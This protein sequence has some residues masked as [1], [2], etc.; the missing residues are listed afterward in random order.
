MRKKRRRCKIGLKRK[1]RRMK[2]RKMRKKE[3]RKTRLSRKNAK[4]RNKVR[5]ERRGIEIQDSAA[6]RRNARRQG[7]GEY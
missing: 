6:T 3:E 1:K 5:K 2:R 7:T 4:F